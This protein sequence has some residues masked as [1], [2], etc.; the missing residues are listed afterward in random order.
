MIY[1]LR[2]QIER[3]KNLEFPYRGLIRYA[4]KANQHRKILDEVRQAGLGI[5][6]S[7]SYEV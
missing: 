3:L 7:S 6:A 2:S 1:L 5:D 4:M